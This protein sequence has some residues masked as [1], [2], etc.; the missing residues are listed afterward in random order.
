MEAISLNPVKKDKWICPKCKQDTQGERI[1]R[2]PLV[3]LLLGF[4]PLERYKC[5]KCKRSY[6]SFKR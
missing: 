1:P 4:L 5:Y 2:G 3:K 6:Y